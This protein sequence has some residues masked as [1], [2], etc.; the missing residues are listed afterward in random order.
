M[1]LKKFT[2]AKARVLPL[3][4]LADTSGSMSV[5]GKIAALNEAMQNMLATFAQ[6]SVR[7]AQIQVGVITFGGEAARLHLPLTAVA[8]IEQPLHLS[9]D[10]RTPMGGAFE[11]AQSLVEDQA[12]ITS[13]DYQP[14]II[15]VSDGIPTDN[16]QEKFAE[17]CQSPR[18]DKAARFAMAIGSEADEQMLAQFNNDVEAGVFKAHE[19]GDIHRFFRAVTMSVTTRSRSQTPNDLIPI[20]FDELPE[21]GDDDLGLYS[22]GKW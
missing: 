17:L 20:D 4:I 19:A 7:Q 14:V 12:L 15:L 9:A 13:R 11:L 21:E 6:E 16:W 2:A 10:G 5:N 22:T 18:A 3:I 8:D 1:S